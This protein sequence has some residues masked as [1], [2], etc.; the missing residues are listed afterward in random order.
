MQTFNK[1]PVSVKGLP[2]FQMDSRQGWVLQAPWGSGNSGILTFAAELDTEMAA[3]WYE[4]HEP[5]FWKETA[6]AVG[7]TEHPIGADDVF[8]DVDTGPVL[9]EFGSVASGFGIGAA[10]TVGR[11]DHVVPLTL[12]AV[13][14]AWPSPFGFL[15]P[16]IMGKVGADSW[17][18]GEVALLFCMTRP[19]Q[20]DTVIS[21]SGDIPGIVWGLLAFYWGVGLL[22]IVLE[23]RGIRRIIARHRA[24]KRNTVEPD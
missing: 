21:F 19:N 15:V 5:D 8:M 7:F 14:C 6:W 10:N 9:F 12:E 11:L 18:L 2:A 1:S 17:S 20:T 24:S 13:A 3:S 23:L 22:F 16:G 4:A